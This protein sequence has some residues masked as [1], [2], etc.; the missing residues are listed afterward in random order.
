[1]ENTLDDVGWTQCVGFILISPNLVFKEKVKL[2]VDGSNFLEED[3]VMAAVLVA[4]LVVV[5]VVV[6]VGRWRRQD[7]SRVEDE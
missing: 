3:L 7:G 2:F 4:V 5:T 1:M 6:M